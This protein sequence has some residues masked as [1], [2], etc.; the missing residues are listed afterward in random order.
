MSKAIPQRIHYGPYSV[1]PDGTHVAAWVQ[2]STEETARSVVVF[3]LNGGAPTTVCGMCAGRDSEFPPPVSWS[4]DGKFV[5]L[6]FWANG[7][8]AVPLQSGQILPALAGNGI[9]SIEDAAALPNAEP[10]A[11]ANAF[12]GPTPAVYAYSKSSAQRN[13]YRVPVP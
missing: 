8:F 9:R 2:G 3:P 6:G 1:S 10:F 13:I 4:P 7:A 5:H 12:P 11:V